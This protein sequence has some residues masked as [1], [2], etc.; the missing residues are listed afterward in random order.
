M[1]RL[2]LLLVCLMAVTA[3][4]QTVTRRLTPKDMVYKVGTF[5]RASQVTPGTTVT[6]YGFTPINVLARGADA[7]GA[8]ACNDTINAV[9]NEV[10]AAGGG[11][12]YMPA[13][14]YRIN[15]EIIIQHDN[16]TLMGDGMGATIIRPTWNAE[17]RGIIILDSNNC[18]VSGLSVIGSACTGAGEA[19]GIAI[20]G[21]RHNT[22]SFCAADSCDDSGICVGYDIAAYFAQSE[23]DRVNPDTG[24]DGAGHIIIGNVVTNTVEGTGIEIMRADSLTISNNQVSGASQYC[25]R[26]DATYGST[27]TGNVLSGSGAEAI[28]IQGYG[29][30]SLVG[31]LFSGVI[32][33]P[34]GVTVTGNVVRGVN[35]IRLMQGATDVVISS[36]IFDG[37]YTGANIILDKYHWHGNSSALEYAW[38]NVSIIGNTLLN[39]TTGILVQGQGNGLAIRDNSIGEFLTTGIYFRANTDSMTIKD[40]VVGGNRI[41]IKTRDTGGS[42]KH[43]VTV[44][45]DSVY[46]NIERNQFWMGIDAA[47]KFAFYD[48]DYPKA[49]GIQQYVKMEPH[50][51]TDFGVYGTGSNHE[52]YSFNNAMNCMFNMAGAD[53]VYGRGIDLYFPSGTY[54]MVSINRMLPPVRATGP[55]IPKLLIGGWPRDYSGGYLDPDGVIA[56]PIGSMFRRVDNDSILY[57]KVAGGLSGWQYIDVI[58]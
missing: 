49:R 34:I 56:A 27:I 39:G 40:V 4:A 23:E 20:E 22:I 42:D 46:V 50:H 52:I 9:L 58:P 30:A 54:P 16:V 51:I 14:T 6:R 31:S 19:V 53:S 10:G 45:G 33:E 1:K 48:C 7:S 37:P 24:I 15:D 26:V 21:G 32:K 3:N 44:K 18:I 11:V 8:T 13:G 47:N 38:K 17:K 29:D 55:G 57:Y 36:N 12:V 25:I 2:V 5:A 35:G 41:W 43:G 28:S